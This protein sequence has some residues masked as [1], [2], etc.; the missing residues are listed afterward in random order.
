[1]LA[2]FHDMYHS[3][4]ASRDSDKR[5]SYA[6]RV[7]IVC[8]K[9]DDFDKA[10]FRRLF[11]TRSRRPQFTPFIERV[12]VLFKYIQGVEI[13]AS[14][15]DLPTEWVK[16]R[17]ANGSIYFNVLT[18]AKQAESPNDPDSTAGADPAPTRGSAMRRI[19]QVSRTK[20]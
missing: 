5:G 14:E 18:G 12:T 11:S 16:K 9:L 1:M 13:D 4:Q 6:D 8:M 15:E 3:I 7:C 19:F 17:R 2:F 20:E 10:R